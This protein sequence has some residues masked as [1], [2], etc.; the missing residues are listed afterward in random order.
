MIQ[1]TERLV[2]SLKRRSLAPTSQKTFEDEDLIAILNEELELHVVPL[3]LSV[4]EDYFLAS[5]RTPIT[6]NLASYNITE[7]AIGGALK[8]VFWTLDDEDQSESSRNLNRVSLVDSLDLFVGTGEP[9]SY[10]LRGNQIVLCPSPATSYGYVE[11]W[12]LGKASELVATTSCTKIVS[13]TS[14]AGTTTFTVDTD[15]TSSLAIGDQVDFLNSQSPL[16]SWAID[17][18]ITAITASTIAVLTTDVADSLGVTVLPGEDDYICPR[19]KANVPTI[20]QEFHPYLAERGAARVVQ[21]LGHNDKLQAING[22]LQMMEKSL[23]KI[24]SNRVE[25]DA[26]AIVNRN[27][28]FSYVGANFLRGNW[29]R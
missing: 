17:V 15:L 2:S 11:Q 9:R 23:M 4:R 24:I 19:L 7:R 29:R 25:N 1:T 13:S 22:N 20:P 3:I 26:R 27:G 18:T 10:S 21:A 8:D 14:L 28:I 12:Y 16:G 6:A 5:H